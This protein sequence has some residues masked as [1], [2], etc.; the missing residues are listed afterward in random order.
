MRKYSSHYLECNT[1][2]TEEPKIILWKNTGLERNDLSGTKKALICFSKSQSSH[3]FN[4]F[5]ALS[6]TENQ[7]ICVLCS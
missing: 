2:V 1:I 6:S 4:C 5:I 7:D 3:L